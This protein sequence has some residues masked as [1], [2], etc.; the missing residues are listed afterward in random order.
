MGGGA[1]TPAAWAEAYAQRGWQVLPVHSVRSGRCTCGATDCSSPGKHPRTEHGL[2]D[3]T[4]DETVILEWWKRWPSANIG[5]ATGA[6]SGIVVLDFDTYKD[7]AVVARFEERFGPLP[8]TPRVRTGGG[9]LHVYLAWAEEGLSNSAGKLM[10][11]VDV[12]AGG[13]SAGAS[14]SRP[15]RMDRRHIARNSSGPDARSHPGGSQTARADC[16]SSR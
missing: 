11:G 2:R 13:G 16:G 10:P 9:G 6:A 4:T 3:A 12:R 7:P 15:L 8:V 14:R 1:M 5:I